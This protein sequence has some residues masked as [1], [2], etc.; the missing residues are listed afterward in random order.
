MAEGERIWMRDN[1][2][3]F[4]YYPE[5][6]YPDINVFYQIAQFVVSWKNENV[7]FISLKSLHDTVYVIHL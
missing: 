2:K 4:I 1:G 7:F 3:S 6:V 5:G